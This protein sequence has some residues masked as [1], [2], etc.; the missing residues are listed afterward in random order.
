[1][2]SVGEDRY[3]AAISVTN[4]HCVVSDCIHLIEFAGCLVSISIN[5]EIQQ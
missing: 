2:R 1:M 4:D 5:R 3:N